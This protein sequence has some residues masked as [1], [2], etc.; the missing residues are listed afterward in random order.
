MPARLIVG[1]GNPLRSDDGVGWK[2]AALLKQEL[3]SPEV[4]VMAAQQLTPE[5]AAALARCSEV[6]F[7]DAAHGGQAG[8]IRLEPVHRDPQFQL[9]DFSHDLTPS[10]LLALAYRL[11]AAE[12]AAHLLTLSGADFD[13]G[14]SFSPPVEQAW[15]RFLEQARTLAQP[16]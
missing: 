2:A 16:V 15:S 11:F 8:E 3:S 4:F 5:M 14:E 10:A 1:Y 7:L 9:G 12:P 13:L 6:L